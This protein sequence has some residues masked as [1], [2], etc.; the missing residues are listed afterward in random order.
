MTLSGYTD[1]PFSTEEFGR[2]TD[3]PRQKA[4]I[5]A[6]TVLTWDRNKYV[7]VRVEGLEGVFNIKAGYCYRKPGRCGEV[8][9]FTLKELET[10]PCGL[11]EDQ[12]QA[13]AP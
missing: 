4:P 11:P 9:T 12:P 10:L 3:V 7:D 6:V 2:G 5:R 1:Y 13:P 8:P